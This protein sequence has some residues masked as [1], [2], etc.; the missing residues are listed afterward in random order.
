M[1]GGPREQVH[2]GG[3]PSECRGAPRAGAI[4]GGVRVS[5]GGPESA[6]TGSVHEHPTAWSPEAGLYLNASKS[7]WKSRRAGFSPRI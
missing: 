1:P 3:G 7:D 4:G 5:A 6:D 2:V